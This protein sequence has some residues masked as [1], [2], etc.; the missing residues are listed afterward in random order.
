MYEP[1][2]FSGLDNMKLAE[3]VAREIEDH[4]PDAV[5]IDAG[6][7]EGVIDRLRQLGYTV[8]EVPFGGKAIREDKYVNRRA[9]MWDAMRAWLQQGG[10]IPE[11]ERLQAE[12]SI[13]EYGYDA[14]G[15]I[16]LEAKDKIK[17][18]SGRS[19]DVADAAA[20]T[21]AAP[22]ASRFAAARVQRAN[23]GYSFF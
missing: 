2:L 19:P 11:D 13:P 16:Q 10:S 23:T 21:F 17:E 18:R 5:F 3:I 12:L 8:M 1:L 20:L 6:R 15:R 4:R 14:K 22:V 7:G 9:E